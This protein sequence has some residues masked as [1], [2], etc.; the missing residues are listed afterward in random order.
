MRKSVELAR[1]RGPFLAIKGSIYDPNNFRWSP[2]QPAIETRQ[3]W[4]RPPLDWNAL[5]AGI[6]T[7]GIR[8]AAQTTVAP[9]GTIATVSGCEGYGCEPVFALAYVRHVNDNGKDL[10]LQYTSPLFEQ[11]LLAAGLDEQ[12][13]NQIIAEVNKVGT[14]QHI[15]ALPD[16]IRHTFVV[17]SDITPEEHVRMQAAI[18]TFVDNSISKTCNFPADATPEDVAQAY[19]LAWDLGCKGLTVYVTGSREKVTL[20]THA[21]RQAKEKKEASVEAPSAKETEAQLT[22]WRE[23]KKPRATI[24]QGETTRISTPLGRT[25][26]T[27]NRNGDD[28]PFEVFIQTS[29]AGSD[30]AAVSDAIGRLISYILRLASPVSPRDRLK[31]V[32][33]QL[34]GIGGGRPLGFGVQRVLSLPDGVA[35]VLSDYLDRTA[36]QTATADATGN[37]HPNGHPTT[38]PAGLWAEQHQ[39][40]LKIGDLCPECGEASLLNEEGC[41]T[42]A[43]CGYSEC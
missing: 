10:Q 19:M 29:K 31:E 33:N 37:A 5:V 30:T 42:C 41:R 21:T 16:H 27:V 38:G 9:T 34:S 2:P 40:T 43:S 39:P 24:L 1:D 15:E 7:Y 6:K 14:C 18:Q 26:V 3:T 23:S 36:E 28:Q 32:I 17:S 8:N 20:E 22:L 35:Q 11:A 25:Y 13:R 4:G 12:T